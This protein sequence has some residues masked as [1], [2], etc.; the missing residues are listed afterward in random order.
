MCLYAKEIIF[1][2][3]N[4]IIDDLFW[5]VERSLTVKSPLLW[6]VLQLP[7]PR[8]GFSELTTLETYGGAREERN[9]D[10][11]TCFGSMG[12]NC[13]ETTLRT[14]RKVSCS[15]LTTSCCCAA[16]RS[17]FSFK[18]LHN[19]SAA[20]G[21]TS[22]EPGMYYYGNSSTLKISCKCWL[23]RVRH[24][25]GPVRFCTR[26]IGGWWKKLCEQ[27]WRTRCSLFC[28]EETNQVVFIRLHARTM[29]YTSENVYE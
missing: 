15:N 21:I 28:P 20:M 17:Y 2:F 4:P 12:D 8:F 5:L 22:R 16:R 19:S 27:L 9:T 25:F 18:T 6:T 1:S 3:Q 10:C 23:R 26:T 29:Y 7:L 14:Q 11:W 13:C 24:I